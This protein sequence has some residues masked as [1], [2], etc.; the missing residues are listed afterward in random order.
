MASLFGLA[1]AAAGSSTASGARISVVLG[2]RSAEDLMGREDFAA[3]PVDLRIATED[4]SAGERG[5]V[6]GPLE[7]LL[8]DGAAAVYCCGPTPMMRRCAEM[9]SARGIR[10]IVSLENNM[11]CG[12]G[13][14]LGCAAPRVQGDYALVCRDGPIFDAGEIDWD[15]LP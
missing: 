13:A 3:L 12:F 9:A 4:G 7:E 10:C 5:L 1:A 14:C 6:T 8:A 2:A 15:G 11:A